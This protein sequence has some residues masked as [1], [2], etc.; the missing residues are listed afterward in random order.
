MPWRHKAVKRLPTTKVKAHFGQIVHEVAMTGTPMVIQTRGADQAVII[1]LRDL[2]AFWPPDI[3]LSAPV[4]QQVRTVLVTV[5]QATPRLP[6]F[7]K[8]G[9]GANPPKTALPE[10]F[11]SGHP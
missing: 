4:R 6:S 5:P 8:G 2:H 1:S 9:N 7:A 10:V 11:L 3:E